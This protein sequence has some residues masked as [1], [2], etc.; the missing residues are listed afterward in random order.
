[1]VWRLLPMQEYLDDYK[2]I[3]EANHLSNIFL[4]T[5]QSAPERVKWIDESSNGFI[6]MV[7]SASTT[8]KNTVLADSANYFERIKAMNLK[9][10][11][12]IGFG[13]ADKTGFDTAC[14]YASGAIIG[15]AFV[16]A[17]ADSKDIKADVALFVNKI[18]QN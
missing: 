8:G 9:N 2:T 12:I 3:F 7:S 13:I 5:P 1:M 15:S 4:I 18:K 16:K 11:T 10:P 6:Y 17:M 14:K